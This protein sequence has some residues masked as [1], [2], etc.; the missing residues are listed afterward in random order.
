MLYKILL[1][2]VILLSHMTVLLSQL[3]VLLYHYE[4]LLHHLQAILSS[5]GTSVLSSVPAVLFCTMTMVLPRGTRSLTDTS[6]TKEI[7]CTI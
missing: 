4:V 6:A 7:L 3:E 5:R 1:S 2:N